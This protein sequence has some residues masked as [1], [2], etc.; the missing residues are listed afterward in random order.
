MPET[1]HKCSYCR[2][3]DNCGW[4]N[5]P[6]DANCGD[7]DPDMKPCE[8]CS[9]AI[10]LDREGFVEDP[11]KGILCLD[12]AEWF[13]CNGQQPSRTPWVAEPEADSEDWGIAICSPESEAIVATIHPSDH[14]ADARDWVD[15]AFIIQ[16]VNSHDN[17]V[18]ALEHAVAMMET[19]IDRYGD[20]AKLF[21]L[22]SYRETLRKA[23]TQA[24]ENCLQNAPQRILK[25][26]GLADKKGNKAKVPE[27]QA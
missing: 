23:E 3:K 14:P 5:Q 19:H 12:C 1:G 22:E 20:P 17:L 4:F 2:K 27:F 11:D 13:Y 16:A 7:Y 9:A 25:L 15:A 18:K 8:N 6:L 10:L 24:W 21:D 26:L